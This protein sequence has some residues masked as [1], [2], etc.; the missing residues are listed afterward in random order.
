VAEEVGREV[1][2]EDDVAGKRRAPV[3][4]LEQIVAEDAFSGTRPS[5][6]RRKAATS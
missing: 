1:L 5:M 4:A 6:A 2:V 3:Q